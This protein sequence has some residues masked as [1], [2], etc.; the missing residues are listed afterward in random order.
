MRRSAANAL[1]L[2]CLM[3]SCAVAQNNNPRLDALK[4][5]ILQQDYPE[6]F[7]TDSYK[8][9]IENVIEVDVDNDG[10][11]EFVVLYFP[12]YRQSAPI[13]IYKI[14]SDLKVSRVTEG[15]A[16]GPLMPVS[17]DYLD[18]HTLGLGVDVE[19]PKDSNLEDFRNIMARHSFNGFVAYDTFYHMDAR[20]GSPWFI[21]LRGV[22]V[23]GKGHDCGSFEF[24][25]VKQIA[26]GGVREDPAKNYLAAWVG[27]SIYVYLITGVSSDGILDK[28]RWVIQ[29][30]HGF[31]GFDP[32]HGLAYTTP[33]GTAILSLK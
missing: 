27:D 9:R 31:N 6:V 33:A 30:P 17:G 12:H 1:V 24:S 2:L 29:T 3:V 25:R 11:K 15:L 7:K 32:G 5:Y 14:T 13:I 22:K 23:P 18:A 20:K 28:N 10:G 8:T 21:D 16:P 19:I 4:K 26:V